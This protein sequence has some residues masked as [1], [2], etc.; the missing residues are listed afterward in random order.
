MGVEG[1]ETEVRMGIVADDV[2]GSNDIGI[3]FAKKGHV[4]TIYD[5]DVLK[6]DL[7]N[8]SPISI[9]NTNSRLDSSELAYA[10]VRRST[11]WLMD[12]GFTHF[13]NKT[14]SV[15]R[16][17]IGPEFDAMLDELDHDFAVVV[18]GFPKNGRQT[19]NGIHYVHGRKLEESEFR[20]DPIHPMTRSDLVGILQS[21]TKRRVALLTHD[22]VVQGSDALRAHM[23]VMKANCNYLILDVVDQ[24]ALQII[25]R[26]IVHERVVCGSSAVAEELAQQDTSRS[27]RDSVFVPTSANS[28][29]LAVAGSLTPQTRVQVEYAHELGHPV[30]ELDTVAA[31]TNKDSCGIYDHLTDFLLQYLR[32]GISPILHASHDPQKVVETVEIGRRL[33][34]SAIETGRFVSD[35]LAQVVHEVMN[36]ILLDRLVVLGGETSDAVCRHLGINTLTVYKEI[37]PGLPSSIALAPHPLLLVLKSGSFGSVDFLIK[38]FD[39]L[40]DKS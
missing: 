32:N 35:A 39:H 25:A 38:A 28:V 36:N 26:A 18:L 9:V 23:E 29:A 12:A 20:D 6:H 24:A 31:M 7:S 37:E 2:T 27:S 40:L 34:L 13:F 3:M 1:G 30:V 5:F 8:V 33:G 17:N 21:Q 22:V 11:R 19:V 16:G 14:C 4:T 15:F 10:K